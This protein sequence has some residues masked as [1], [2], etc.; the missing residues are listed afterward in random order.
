MALAEWLTVRPAMREYKRIREELGNAALNTVCAEAHCPNI[1]ECWSVGTATFIVL[2]NL[3][4]RGCRFCS[5]PKSLHGNALDPEEPARL[6]KTI[7]KWG[8]R[9][10]VVTSV[11]RDD[12]PD[13]GSAHF[14]QCVREAKHLNPSTK[15]RGAYT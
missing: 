1:T 14:A 8:L 4:T 12:L 6:A 10:A 2:G 13:Q 9:Y 5:V 15:N 11:C 3:C 7:I